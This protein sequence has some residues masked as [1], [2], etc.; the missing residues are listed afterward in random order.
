LAANFPVKFSSSDVSLK[1][2]AP[3]PNEHFEEIMKTWLGGE[4]N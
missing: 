3:K 2:P 4:I 1:K